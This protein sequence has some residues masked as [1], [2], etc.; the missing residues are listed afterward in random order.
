MTE[1]EVAF[2]LGVTREALIKL[3][4]KGISL[5]GS[6]NTVKLPA[7][8]IENEY[9]VSDEDLDTFI[10]QFEAEEPGRH[11]P[12]DVRRELLTEANHRCGICRQPVS[13]LQFHH[14]LEWE[15]IKHH[16]PAH[17][18]AVCGTCHDDCGMGK[19]DKKSQETY[20][21]RLVGQHLDSDREKRADRGEKREDPARATGIPD[22]LRTTF[23][24]LRRSFESLALQST[25]LHHVLV[26]LK[27]ISGIQALPDDASP[28]AVVINRPGDPR[29]VFALNTPPGQS[30]YP[31]ALTR[32]EIEAVPV[33]I[34]QDEY[35]RDL[36]GRPLAKWE[37]SVVRMGYV[38]GDD[39]VFNQFKNLPE[40]A[41]NALLAIPD[42]SISR[43]PEMIRPV[44]RIRP[45]RL[46][47]Y[48]F[49]N[50]PQHPPRDMSNGW[51]AGGQLFEE[52]AIIDCPTPGT[53]SRG[54]ADV[55]MLLLHLLGWRANAGATL[56]ASRYHWQGNT[57]VSVELAQH[58]PSDP[59]LPMVPVHRFYSVLGPAGGQEADACWASVWAIDRL[60][61]MVG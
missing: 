16:D 3:I 29:N 57:S 1:K 36:R 7:T 5:P 58:S 17:M 30:P 11:P 9:S 48:V 15:R 38:F 28:P 39:K 4:D 52:G 54:R 23:K 55:W 24:D 33:T 18:I 42:D 51:I 53:D 59:M 27:R 47:R 25:G 12:A 50:V 31:R 35:V 56:R 6:K 46:I 43:L 10:D 21:K 34:E 14:I 19:I 13:R 32:E 8:R 2:L 20:K 45:T 41:G 49:G 61:K 60:L 40:A 37:P 22:D 26:E 44:C